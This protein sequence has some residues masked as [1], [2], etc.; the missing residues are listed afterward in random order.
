MSKAEDMGNYFR[1]PM[2]N[3]DLNYDKFYPNGDGSVKKFESY[4]SN[5]TNQLDVDGMIELLKQ[6]GDIEE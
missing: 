2:D 4:T 6:V 1:I 5:N 3:R